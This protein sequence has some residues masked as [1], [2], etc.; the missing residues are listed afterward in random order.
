ME[1]TAMDK[2][3]ANA[4]P[5]ERTWEVAARTLEGRLEA[6]WHFLPLA[7]ER[8]DEDVEYVHQLRVWSRRA[9]AA[10][11]LY[12]DLLPR[13]RLAW[14]QSQLKR[15][16]QAAGD[17]RDCDVLAARLSREHPGSGRD[18]WLAEVRAERASAQ[19]P[20]EDMY[21]RLRHEGRFDRR[22][23]ALLR[24]LRP[25]GRKKAAPVPPRFGD[26]AH[27]TL[28]PLV[29]KFF[30]AAPSHAADTA[31][32]HRFRI[33]GKQLRYAMELVAGAFP[34]DLREALYPV[35]EALQEK[36]GEINDLATARA[37]LRRRLRDAEDPE[38]ARHVRRGLA[39][40][41]ARLAQARHAFLDWCTPQLLDDLRAGLAAA[42]EGSTRSAENTDRA[43][44]RGG[45][46]TVRR[47]GT[48]H[49]PSKARHSV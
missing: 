11:K 32:L 40:E 18:A 41:E 29:E 9:A 14:V 44:R 2:W 24:R 37:R 28:A 30:R 17:A 1:S 7:A 12:A 26:W 22:V 47:A 21:R 4:G 43:P 45:Q 6:V 49:G 8:A 16:R 39:E 46:R 25:G 48:L 31:S 13:R 15:L 5:E 27:A 23:R 20:I 33:R 3:V 19:Q 10:L 35:V 42:L 36:L 38:R 34:P